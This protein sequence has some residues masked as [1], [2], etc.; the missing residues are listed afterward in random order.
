M[1]WWLFVRKENKY[2]R[3]IPWN[4]LGYYCNLGSLRYRTSIP[5]LPPLLRGPWEVWHPSQLWQC[6]VRTKAGGQGQLPS[7]TAPLRPK[8]PMTCSYRPALRHKSL[9]GRKW[10]GARG[11]VAFWKES[12]PWA[13]RGE[14]DVH[15]M[16]TIRSNE[17]SVRIEFP[18]AGNSLAVA[19][20]GV[21][22]FWDQWRRSLRILWRKGRSYSQMAPPIPGGFIAIGSCSSAANPLVRFLHT[23]WTDS[24]A[25]SLHDWIRL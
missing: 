25:V 21:Q 11:G 8:L 4:V 19:V 17:H 23:A 22:G 15:A 9:G 10:E 18:Q 1:I 16:R 14:T 13:Q 2:N 24:R 20:I 7:P 3:V 5:A 12:Y 6:W